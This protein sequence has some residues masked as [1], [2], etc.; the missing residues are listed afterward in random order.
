MIEPAVDLT[1][2]TA[3]RLA[4]GKW[5][6]REY[7]VVAIVAK[8]LRPTVEMPDSQDMLEYSYLVTDGGPIPLE[9]DVIA[10]DAMAAKVFRANALPL[11][12]YHKQELVD[13]AIGRPKAAAGIQVPS[14][15]S[16]TGTEVLQNPSRTMKAPRPRD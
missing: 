3:N 12:D 4:A 10:S 15:P 13:I 8:Q 9:L 5:V 14:Q 1:A 6:Y 16:G 7:P 2:V 11:S